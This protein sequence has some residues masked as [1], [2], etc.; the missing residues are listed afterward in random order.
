MYI[1]T[2][3]SIEKGKG[4]AV[5]GEKPNP[6]GPNEV[7]VM[8]LKPS[9]SSWKVTPVKDELE[10]KTVEALKKK[11]KLKID[12]NDKWHGSL[13]VA[14]ELFERASKEKKSI[15]IY[16]HGYNNDVDDVVKAA[17]LIEEQYGDV[18]VVPFTWPANGGGSFTGA[19]AYLSDKADARTSVGALNRVVGKIQFYHKLLTQASKATAKKKAHD[20]YPNNPE[21]ASAAF[22]AIINK[23]CAVSINLLCHSMGNYL[24]KHTLSTGDNA[25]SKL[26]FDNIC[27]VAADANN[28]NH[29]TWVEKLD[30]RKRLYIV[31]NENDFALRFSRI[32]PGEEQLARLGHYTLKLNADNAHYIDV[33]DAHGVNTDHAYFK[34]NAISQNPELKTMFEG[35]FTGRAIEA[36]LTYR[37]VNNS[38]ILP[39]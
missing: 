35:M 8:Q 24:L 2:N 31:I 37:A 29:Q 11:H 4:L 27:L 14:C 22:T 34:G 7:R 25:T 13:E 36:N 18:I 32:K 21:K 26:V 33:T 10:K 20:K 19:A 39:G 15:L 12:I 28:K 16:V 3:R 38:Y 30:V 1:I 9:G 17:Q 6:S 23:K 5:L